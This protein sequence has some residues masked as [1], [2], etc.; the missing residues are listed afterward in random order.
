ML[1]SSQLF[2]SLSC[3]SSGIEAVDRCYV[4]INTVCFTG[5]IFYKHTC[6][7]C[8]VSTEVRFAATSENCMGI[9]SSPMCL[10]K[11]SYRS[12]WRSSKD[13]GS[14]HYIVDVHYWICNSNVVSHLCMPRH[15]IVCCFEGVHT[16]PCQLQLVLD[17][18]IYIYIYICFLPPLSLV[19]CSGPTFPANGSIEAYH[20][21]TEGAEIFFRCNPGFVAAGRMRAVCGAD[22][23]WNPEPFDLA[24]TH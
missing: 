3:Y 21:T 18:Y 8:M 7:L 12:E 5:W 9:S 14:V 22:G 19:N 11:N 13:F 10:Y 4:S 15:K 1:N 23:R 20:N 2:L 16:S 24:C 17:I 6:R